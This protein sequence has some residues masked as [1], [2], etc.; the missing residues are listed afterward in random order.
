M[1][2]SST[3]H[4]TGMG[5]KGTLHFG[6]APGQIERDGDW[7]VGLVQGKKPVSRL[8]EPWAQDCTWQKLWWEG[9]TGV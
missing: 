2:K 8:G 9:R 5:S 1:G 7:M 6:I 4:E 3:L